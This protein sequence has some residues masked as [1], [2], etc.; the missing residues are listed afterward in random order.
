MTTIPCI[1][2]IHKADGAFNGYTETFRS[3]HWIF[4]DLILRLF[5]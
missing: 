4:G 5:P 1:N 3:G 2:R